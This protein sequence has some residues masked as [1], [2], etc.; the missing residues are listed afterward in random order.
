MATFNLYPFLHSP[1]VSTQQID[2]SSEEDSRE[3]EEQTV[4]DIFSPCLL[5]HDMLIDA[6]QN[7]VVGGHLMISKRSSSPPHHLKHPHPTLAQSHSL[8]PHY[9]MLGQTPSDHFTTTSTPPSTHHNPHHHHIMAN[10]HKKLDRSQS[11]PSWAQE[12]VSQVST[13]LLIPK[14]HSYI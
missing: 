12:Q 9:E 3:E 4:D 5:S 7:K 6:G 1:Q 13:S 10:L 14:Y 8:L 2:H 11:E